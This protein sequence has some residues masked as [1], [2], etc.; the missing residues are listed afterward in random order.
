MA[1]KSSGFSLI[2]LLVVVA[3]IGIL[4]A[5]GALSYSGYIS[6]TK[7]K[8]AE[9]TMQQ[10][11]LAQ[12]E[13][14]SNNGDYHNNGDDC[15]PTGVTS[16]LIEE[17]LFGDG[18]VITEESGYEMCIQNHG[19]TYLVKAVSSTS[20]CELSDGNKVPKLITMTANGAWTGKNKCEL[21]P[22]ST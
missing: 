18:D 9:N 15:T 8:S 14:Y 16:N 21:G 20:K 12:T 5:I 3:I 4:A 22:S 2:E 10:I 19:T 11:A 17:N 1:T 7:Q 6:G 13:Y